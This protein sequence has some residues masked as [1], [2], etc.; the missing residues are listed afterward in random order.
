MFTFGSFVIPPS[1]FPQVTGG[2]GEGNRTPV[3][4]LGRSRSA[5]EPHP[6]A[7]VASVATA[8]GHTEGPALE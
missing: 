6:R 4:S 2:A 8:P 3:S 7:A 5:I 1:A